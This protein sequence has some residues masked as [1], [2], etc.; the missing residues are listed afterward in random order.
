MRREPMLRCRL[1]MHGLLSQEE[2]E[3][4]VA[5]TKGAGGLRCT[6]LH[7]VDL[8]WQTSALI[9]ECGL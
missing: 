4:Y 3:E 7:L 5:S 6:S 2:A 1:C 9:A 8:C